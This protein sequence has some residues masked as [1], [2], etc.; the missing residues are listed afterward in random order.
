M[1]ARAH[2]P[3][4]GGLVTSGQSG[5]G[6]GHMYPESAPLRPADASPHTGP[7]V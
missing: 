1:F 5:A 6:C 4:T 7:M 3:S 2:G